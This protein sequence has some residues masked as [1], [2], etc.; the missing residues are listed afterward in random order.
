MPRTLQVGADDGEVVVRRA[1]P[2]GA[3]RVVD[4]V[5]DGAAV[6][7]QV[8]VA[9]D[10]GPGA[11]SRSIQSANGAGRG[12]LAGDLEPVDDRLL[13]VAVLVREVPEV[14]RRLDVRVLREQVQPALGVRARDVRRH[15]DAPAVVRHLVAEPLRVVR[16]RQLVGVVHQVG[17][18]VDAEAVDEQRAVGVHGALGPHRLLQL[19][20]DDRL[21]VVDQVLADARQVVRRRRC[22]SCSRSLRGPMPEYSSSRGVSTEPAGDDDLLARRDPVAGAGVAQHLD[23]RRRGRPTSRCASRATR[24]GSTGSTRCQHRVQVHHRRRRA[25]AG[26][27][28]VADVEEAG[29]VAVRRRVPVGVLLHAERRAARPRSSR[30]RIAL[31]SCL[32]DQAVRARDAVVVRVHLVVRPARRSPGRPSRSSR[33]GS[34]LNQIIVLCDE[35]P[36]STFAREWTMCAL[37]RGCSVVV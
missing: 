19:P 16:E 4:G 21:G 36:P 18:V 27:G 28:V 33:P 24:S 9:R 25:H 13:V 10:V 3:R 11:T 17:P 20:D 37:P 35:Q 30:S 34:G 15:A 26:R 6:R 12:H 23:R 1:H 31:R 5:M 7:G 2:A 22:R 14:E 8:V 32:A 29:T